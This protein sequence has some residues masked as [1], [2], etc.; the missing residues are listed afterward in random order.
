MQPMFCHV[1]QK[2]LALILLLAFLVTAP[3]LLW[4][5]IPA[6]DSAQ[7][8]LLTQEFSQGNFERAFHPSLPPLLTTLGGTLNV[9]LHD[10]FLANKVAGILLFL[11]GVPGT[12]LLAR[13]LRGV[14]IALLSALL[15]AI[16]PSIL[17]LATSGGVDA[18]K[19]ALLPWLAWATCRWCTAG[20]WAWGTTVGGLGGLLS[21]ARG[22]GLFFAGAAL[23]LFAIASF[24]RW[25]RA[26]AHPV[27]RTASLLLAAS[28]LSL[29]ILPWGFY[30]KV[31]TG[32]FVTHVSH[33]K[34][35]ELLGISDRWPRETIIDE[36]ALPQA[37]IPQEPS[38]TGTVHPDSVD[39]RYFYQGIRWYRNLEQT[40]KGFFIP[41]LLLALLGG[42]HRRGAGERRWSRGEVIPLVFIALNLAI[43]FPTSIMTSRYIIATI[44]LYLHYAA[45]GLVVAGGLLSRSPLVTARRLQHL[46][47]VAVLGMTLVCQKELDI[48]MNKDKHGQQM[49]L[50][51]IGHWIQQHAAELPSY[52]ALPN[53][54][55][56][57]TGRLPVILETDGRLRFY[58]QADAL[59]L[60]PFYQ[61]RPEQIVA[62]CRQ[63]KVA[64]VLYD[65]RMEALSPGFGQYWPQ[66]P[67]FRPLDGTPDFPRNVA[68]MRLLAFDPHR[69]AQTCPQP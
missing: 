39:L 29:V 7:Y 47:W 28:V 14:Q 40:T 61:Y 31:H 64:L 32:L 67:A 23:F 41:Y 27:R 6:R 56:Y 60:Y 10:A 15:Y 21:L 57:H 18:G 69:L 12:Y 65:Q 4:R 62:I 1:E 33:F 13:E 16:C 2:K 20:G 17:D 54:S 50:M 52:G 44:P 5:T 3:S 25:R 24:R 9:L 36:N 53:N 43:F 51:D 46:G 55:T 45:D 35:Y 19:L 37:A 42:L 59:N 34:I 30:Q 63:G 8:A 11:L 49:A 58:A 22:E 48:F 68:G 66:D 26:D 38:V